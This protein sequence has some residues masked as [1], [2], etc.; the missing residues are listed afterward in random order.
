MSGAQPTTIQLANASVVVV[1]QAETHPGDGSA[2]GGALS[3]PID[4][5]G[6]DAGASAECLEVVCCLSD[7]VNFLWGIVSVS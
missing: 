5:I 4:S 3:T 6:S 2:S 7:F 1:V